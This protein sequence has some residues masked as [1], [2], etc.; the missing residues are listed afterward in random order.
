VPTAQKQT[1][2]AVNTAID[3]IANG[4]N[5][6]LLVVATGTGKTYTAFQIILETCRVV[7]YT[8]LAF[9]EEGWT[10]RIPAPPLADFLIF[11]AMPGA[12]PHS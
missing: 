5:R 8:T 7:S 12:K 1:S 2:S 4:Q 6:W 11:W 9:V 10:S 3:A